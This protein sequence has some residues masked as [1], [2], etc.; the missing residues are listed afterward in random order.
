[1]RLHPRLFLSPTNEFVLYFPPARQGS[2]FCILPNHAVSGLAA[3]RNPDFT[4]PQKP[5]VVKVKTL[6]A[7]FS[8]T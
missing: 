1:M 5:A 6:F 4:T 3:A 2:S 8:I 7:L